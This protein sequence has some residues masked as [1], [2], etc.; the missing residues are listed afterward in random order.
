MTE[1]LQILRLQEGKKVERRSLIA[2]IKMKSTM[3]KECVIS[4]ITRKEGPSSPSGVNILMRYI[5]RKVCAKRA[6]L[7]N[8]LK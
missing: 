4:V 8:I 3:L 6:T 1:P 7:H 2:T 5:T